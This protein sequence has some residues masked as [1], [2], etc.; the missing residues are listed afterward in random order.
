MIQHLL[1]TLGFNSYSI[2]YRPV[3]PPMIHGWASVGSLQI[4]A[5]AGDSG[6]EA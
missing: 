1:V 4:V 6:G 5:P 3:K 2:G